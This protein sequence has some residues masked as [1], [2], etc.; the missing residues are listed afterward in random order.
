MMHVHIVDLNQIL[1]EVF[2]RG[3]TGFLIDFVLTEYMA[4]P[5]LSGNKHEISHSV[6]FN[7]KKN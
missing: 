7:G 1:A 6:P 5:P 3:D 2:D 4:F